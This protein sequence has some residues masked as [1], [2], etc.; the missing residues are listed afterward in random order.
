VAFRLMADLLVAFHLAFVLFVVLGGL[1]VVRYRRAAFIHVPVA[2]WGVAIELSG[3]VCPL[4]PLEVHLRILGGQAG[5]S[6]G[7]VDH[8]LIPVLY[9]SGLTREHQVWLGI[10]VCALNLGVYGFVLRRWVRE[11][12][13][14]PPPPTHRP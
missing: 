9:P 12:G 1:I 8:Y 13:E 7:F 10:L 4:T 5:Y 6:G 14:A 3:R 2:L 11:S